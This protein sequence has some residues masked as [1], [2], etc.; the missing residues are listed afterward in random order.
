MGA[1]SFAT[2]VPDKNGSQLTV[3]T[4]EFGAEDALVKKMTRWRAENCYHLGDMSSTT[5]GIVFRVLA[6]EQMPTLENVPNLEYESKLRVDLFEYVKN[7]TIQPTFQMSISC[8]HGTSRITSGARYISGWTSSVCLSFP[9]TAEPKSHRTGG[10][11][12]FGIR[13][14]RD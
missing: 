12:A 7:L 9:R 14:W 3:F 10:P 5:V 4:E 8:P 2:Q 6:R 11:I 1:F 13:S